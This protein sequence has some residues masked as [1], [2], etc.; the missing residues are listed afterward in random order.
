MVQIYIFEFCIFG[1]KF[2]F[3]PLKVHR[4]LFEAA[5]A[6]YASYFFF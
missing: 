1:F 2:F 4:D 3:T 5:I 6:S